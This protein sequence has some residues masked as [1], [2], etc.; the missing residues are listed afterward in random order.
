VGTAWIAPAF[1]ADANCAMRIAA[2]P[3]KLV[4]PK[5]LLV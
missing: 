2:E 3:V 5:E 4:E 1:A